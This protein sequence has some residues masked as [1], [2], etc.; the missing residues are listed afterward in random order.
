MED[1]RLIV[2]SHAHYDHAGGIAFVQRASGA[3]V[4]A[5][6]SSAAVLQRGE[7]GPDDPQYGIALRYPAVTGTRIERVGDGDTVRVGPLSMFAYATGG[8][9][10]GGTSWSWRSCD[11]AMCLDFV[12]ADSQT[13]VSAEGFLFTNS[14]TYPGALDDFARGHSTIE[15]LTCDVIITPHPGASRLWERVRRMDREGVSAL[16]DREGCRRYAANAREQ[17]RQRIV[18]ESAGR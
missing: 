14:V 9:T 6:P 5:R 1:I 11:G 15:S 2:N 13:P 18:R 10:P 16:R 7:V 12:Y 4:A 8:H 3:R 17:L